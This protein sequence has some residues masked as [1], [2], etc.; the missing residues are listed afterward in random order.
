MNN[1]PTAT[2]PT[3]AT[4][5]RRRRSP[6]LAL[7]AALAFAGP[8]AFAADNPV[9]SVRDM[10][11][12][13]LALERQQQQIA[14]QWQQEKQALALRVELL[15][16]EREQLQGAIASHDDSDDAIAEARAELLRAQ[17]AL[18]DEQG[19]VADLNRYL[20]HLART[21]Q[22]SLPPPLARTWADQLEQDLPPDNP[23]AA[24]QRHLE[25]F[26][27]LDDF[28]QATTLAEGEIDRGESGR[29]HVRQLYLGASHAWYISANGE[30]RGTGRASASGWVW[31][32]N[33]ALDPDNLLEAMAMLESRG[34][35]GLISL[36]VALSDSDDALAGVR[37]EP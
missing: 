23:S 18:E 36:P 29:L 19:R 33:P 34:R 24:L 3:P 16:R 28:Q 27:M 35:R 2:T 4:R 22:P 20:R 25:L 32:E 10:A 11:A 12:Q 5:S 14:A 9:E 8:S 21:L 37:H 15:S 30:H 17:Q 6:L 1:I 13:W 26:G 7:A 31:E